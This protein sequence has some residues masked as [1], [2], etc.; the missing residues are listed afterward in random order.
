MVNALSSARCS[1]KIIEYL[2]KLEYLQV[3]PSWKILY[4]RWSGNP[5]SVEEGIVY[6]A[7]L[8][9]RTER[10]NGYLS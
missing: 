2:M 1:Q 10:H 8:H 6:A 4:Q 3:W 9:F 5:K 7:T